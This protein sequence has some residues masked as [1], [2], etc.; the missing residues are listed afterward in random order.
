MYA[1]MHTSLWQ[2]IHNQPQPEVMTG[3][4]HPCKQLLILM[5][6]MAPTLVM[7]RKQ[8]SRQC[9]HVHVIGPLHV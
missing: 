8:K 6:A 4:I 9:V 5:V 1:R 2:L 3:A 7:R